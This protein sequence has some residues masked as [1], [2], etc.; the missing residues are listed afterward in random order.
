MDAT[1]TSRHPLQARLR[2]AG[3]LGG[4]LVGLLLA[5]ALPEQ[6]EGAEGPVAVAAATGPR[7]A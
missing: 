6:Y 1:P 2:S 4:P 5:L 7:S 3:R